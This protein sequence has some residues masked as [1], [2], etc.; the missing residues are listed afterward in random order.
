M[1][2]INIF[3]ITILFLENK[4]WFEITGTIHYNTQDKLFNSLKNLI[5]KNNKNCCFKI[6]I[7]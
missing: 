1:V 4:M 5:F 7:S 2:N 3:S 6:I